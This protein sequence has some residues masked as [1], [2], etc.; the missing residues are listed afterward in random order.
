MD[1]EGFA[2]VATISR[3]ARAVVLPPIRPIPH[4]EFCRTIT[5]PDGPLQGTRYIPDAD[6]VHSCLA[7][8]I[9]AG[10]WHRIVAVGAVQTGKS[11]STILVPL[12]RHLTTLRQPCVYSQPTL[13]KLQEAWAGKLSPSMAESGYG[14]WLPDRGQGSKGSQTPK[15]ITFRDPKTR[16]RAGTMY[17]IPGGGSSESAQAA[18]T[19]AVVA[20]DE[21]DS[22]PSR[23]R[24][25]LVLK[26]A[27]SYGAR[28]LR[29]LTS[30]VKSDTTEGEEG[31][32]IL[33]FYRESTSS[34]LHFQCHHCGH[35]QAL[36]FQRVTYDEAN[37]PAAIATARYSCAG[38]AVSWTEDDR[39]RA[40][41]SWR[42]VHQGQQIDQATGAV[43]GD[44]PATVAF[45]LLWTALDSSLRSLG[46]VAAEHWRASRALAME[47]HGPM[48]SFFRDQLCQGYERPALADEITNKGLAVLSERSDY[49]KRTVPH[50]C[51]HMC[52]AVDVQ[53]DRHYF[54]V[55]GIGPDDRWAIVDWG[56]ELLVPYK[57][58]KPERSP[59][60]AD[61]RRVL[62]EMSAKFDA[63]WQ[64]EGGQERMSPLK[65][66]RGIDTG[67][68]TD[69][70]VS[71]LRG[72]PGWRAV[73]GLGEDS[74]K[75]P[76]KQIELPPEARAFA[77]L[78]QPDNWPIP[79]VHVIGDNVRTYVHG[80]L[81]REPYSPASGMIPRG[82]K[83]DDVLC[84]HLSGEVWKEATVKDGKAVPGFWAHPHPR[85]DLLDCVI[86]ALALSRLRAGLQTVNAQRKPVK[87]GRI[88]SV[89]VKR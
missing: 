48:R 50:W 46:Q 76:G 28:A 63:G 78:R 68:L 20:V 6:P 34:R 14:A 89:G 25:E 22:F 71:W 7:R 45:G 74:I 64:K 26:R 77:E 61:R 19:A 84:K 17:L 85:W 47:D 21:V 23:H 58:G 80:C 33:G 72:A 39:Q 62:M 55:I 75:H 88:G 51:T 82:L 69:E 83:A 86:Y 60:P 57:D 30:T 27:D 11:L 43:V 35:W 66:L 42:C 70:I 81:L 38:C 52:G 13:T 32:I 36:D 41:K 9:T 8:E 24:V 79:L 1:D 16:A 37:E 2:D 12:L 65:G 4:A 87:Y 15:F 56:F 10:C 67:Y 40:L 53:G 49:D 31:S 54:V 5:I 29:I 73:K 59:T 3:E 18:V 44:P